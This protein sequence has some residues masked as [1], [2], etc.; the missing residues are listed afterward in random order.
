MC[1]HRG[2]ASEQP[3]PL[4]LESYAAVDPTPKPQSDKDRDA[5]SHQKDRARFGNGRDG[6]IGWM[7]GM[8]W[9][10]GPWRVL[11]WRVLGQNLGGWENNQNRGDDQLREQSHVH[12]YRY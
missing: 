1:F 12:T 9:M 4:F 11:L 5:R 6:Q 8:V 7:A 3:N 2:S 10:G